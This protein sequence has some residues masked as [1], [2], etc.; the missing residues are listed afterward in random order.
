MP[1]HF[2]E[3]AGKRAYTS[4]IVEPL[5]RCAGVRAVPVA[6]RA[7]RDRV[8]PDEGKCRLVI[9][10]GAVPVW[11]RGLWHASHCIGKPA[12]AWFGCEVCWKSLWWQAAQSTPMPFLNSNCLWQESQPRIRW[13]GLSGTPV[14]AE[15]LQRVA[16]HDTGR[17]Q[18]LAVLP[19]P[20]LVTVV[21]PS[22]PM[23]VVT[24]RGRAFDLP[25]D[26]T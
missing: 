12:A 11:V 15:W 25:V 9:E 22:L 23:A 4:E 1:A 6:L 13:V 21:A 7:L 19:E 16:V 26:V 20:Q 14:A 24:G 10:A 3:T 2:N 5:A 17:W 8:L 18:V